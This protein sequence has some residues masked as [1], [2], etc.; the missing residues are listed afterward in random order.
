MQRGSPGLP[1]TLDAMKPMLLDEWPIDLE[2]PA[3]FWTATA[4]LAG[5]PGGELSAQLTILLLGTSMHVRA[6]SD[7]G[8]SETEALATLSREALIWIH[9]YVGAAGEGGTG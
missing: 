3:G 8:T 2:V 5:A 4:D 7:L 6:F 1:P 9:L